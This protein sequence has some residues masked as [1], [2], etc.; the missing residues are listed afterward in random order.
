MTE[1]RAD[2]SAVDRYVDDQLPFAE[3]PSIDARFAEFAA[4]LNARYDEPRF[5]LPTPETLST[6]DVQGI[7]RVAAERFGDADD[8]SF[9]FSGDFEVDAA[10]EMAR[11]Y[12]G[13]LPA[14]GSSDPLSFDEPPPPDGVVVVEAVAGQGEAANVSFLFTSS[15]SPARRD[16]VLARVANEVIGN[17]LTD[18]IREELGDSYSPF[19]SID[20]GGGDSPAVE[21][22]I[23]VSTAPELADDVSAAVL[24]QLD[25]L[26]T[27]G[28]SD[29]EFAN[30]AATVGEQLNFINNAQINDE[31]LGVL[32][33]PEGNAS[34]DDFVDQAAIIATIT[35]GDVERALNDWID[36]DQYIEVQVTPRA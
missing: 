22:Y 28:P 14:G 24:Q 17:R 29:Q 9:S 27:D 25:A 8:W 33:D 26:R 30:A 5:L 18:F 13:T 6:V 10:T 4:L 19:A 7:E 2:G 35:P 3:D 20:L 31:V 36:L 32:V 1:P 23:S 21:T 11:A 16:D 12:L 34:F 15:A